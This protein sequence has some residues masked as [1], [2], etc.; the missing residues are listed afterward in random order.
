MQSSHQER[1]SVYS[2]GLRAASPARPEPLVSGRVLVGR[3]PVFDSFTALPAHGRQ[4][5]AAA[6][7]G[8]GH[9]S[10]VGTAFDQAREFYRSSGCSWTRGLSRPGR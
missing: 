10:G 6:F 2:R 1:T 4:G 9:G 7:R 5:L 8:L 3:E